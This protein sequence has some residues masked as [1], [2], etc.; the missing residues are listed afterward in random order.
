MRRIVSAI[1]PATALVASVLPVTAQAAVPFAQDAH[2]HHQVAERARHP[3]R[4]S[5]ALDTASSAL[6]S[7]YVHVSWNWIKAASGYRIQISRHQDFAKVAVARNK[8]NSRHRP[9]GG[10]EAAVVGKLRDATYYWVRVRKVKGHNASAWSAPVR[11]ATRAHVPDRITDGRGSGGPVPG[12]TTLRWKGTGKY[13]DFYRITTGL[14]P[15]G[16]SKTAATGHRSM[17]FRVNG[18]R[19]SLTLSPEQTAEAG[20]GLGSGRHLFFRILAV[21]KGDADSASRRY[22]FLLHTWVKGEHA[23]GSGPQMR[24]A[25]YSMR[26]ATKDVHGHPWK[27]RQHLIARNIARNHPTVA[28]IEELMPA[29]WT[30]N[31]GGVG[32][33]KSLQEAGAGRY[34]ITRHTSYFSGSPQDTKILY[35]TKKVQLL[36]SCPEDR[37]S[38]YISI[39]DPQHQRVAA[40]AKFKDLGTGQQFYFVSAHLETGNTPAMDDV[41]GRQVAAINAGIRQVNTQNLP[42]VFA[43]DSNSS[44]TAKGSDQAHQVLL[45]AGWYNTLS[46]AKVVNGQYNSVNHYQSPERPSNYGFGSMYDTVMTLGLPGADLWKQVLTGAPWPSDH[47]MVFADVRL[48]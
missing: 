46:A 24:F 16:T 39:P 47:N 28:A 5:T 10:R 43:C 12:S 31:M 22:P 21:R 19:H 11:V 26:V 1:G 40:Y 48:P 44:Q 2:A 8:S 14:T 15:F 32:L 18:D 38:C 23:T 4:A 41:R 17:T 3:G 25:A 20:A 36:S 29:M 45:D 9:A 33:H 30:K 42:V 7:A 13:T 34:D 27:T 6:G 35:D 37:P